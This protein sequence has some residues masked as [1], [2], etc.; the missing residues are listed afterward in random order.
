[1]RQTFKHMIVIAEKFKVITGLVALMASGALLS[2]SAVSWYYERNVQRLAREVDDERLINRDKLR[3]ISD[4]SLMNANLISA[5]AKQNEITA[6]TLAELANL[7]KEAANTAKGA[8][9]TAK[10]AAKNAAQG[11]IR[12]REIKPSSSLK[13]D[14]RKLQEPGP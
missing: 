2:G 10:G 4:Q 13:I 6:E 12:V 9:T 1:M 14:R 11:N 5:V 3:Q 8:A 7:V